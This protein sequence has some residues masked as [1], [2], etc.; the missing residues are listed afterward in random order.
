M[1]YRQSENSTYGGKPVELYKY[2]GTYR[3]FYYTSA[4]YAITYE[5]NTYTPVAMKRSAVTQTTQADDDANVTIDL[6]VALPLVLVYGFQIAPPDL[7]LTIYRGHE[8]GE[9]VQLWQ[10]NVDNISIVRGTASIRVPSDL[11]SALSADFP[12]VYFQTPCNH[13][14]FDS[15]C[16]V[17]RSAWSATGEIVAL[18]VDDPTL[19]TIRWNND[20]T[21]L[22]GDVTVGGDLILPSGERR[23]ISKPMSLWTGT[24][25]PGSET[26]TWVSFP[27]SSEADL[28]GM[29]V[30][31]LSGCDLSWQGDCKNRY[32]NTINFSG[33][34]LIPSD[35]VFATGV[36][37][38]FSVP[39]LTV[40]CN[41]CQP[42]TPY[43]Q[44]QLVNVPDGTWQGGELLGQIG[45]GNGGPYFFLGGG[46]WTADSLPCGNP[47]AE[48]IL[49]WSDLPQVVS[50]NPLITPGV[51]NE[52]NMQYIMSGYAAT[53]NNVG[54]RK[55]RFYLWI[56]GPG[57]TA[58]RLAP[59]KTGSGQGSGDPMSI[60][61]GGKAFE[62]TARTGSLDWFN[63]NMRW[64]LWSDQN[65]SGWLA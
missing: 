14:L 50:G 30:E 33:F 47:P 58:W 52:L 32:N 19:M 31:L 56:K 44:V 24:G 53:C 10:G 38:P 27:F 43:W 28:R 36:E 5:G 57:W 3:S 20:I 29:Q 18:G 23:M 60:V 46:L 61:D 64:N 49:N 54:T 11:A 4:S 2:E 26:F 62:Y 45:Y 13:T 6:P 40:G 9:F 12:N 17:P 55:S 37:P 41:P 21:H 1:T 51:A 15:G 8:A 59:P 63:F 65:N 42:A 48:R 25:A 16:Q 22:V 35:N 7:R 39:D 34:P